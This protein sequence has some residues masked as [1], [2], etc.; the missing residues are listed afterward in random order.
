MP[1]F[2]V[3]R[4]GYTTASALSAQVVTDLLANG[5]TIVY[6]STP[7][8]NWNQGTAG[9]VFK[10]VLEAGP[11]VDPLNATAVS[12]KQPWRIMIDVQGSQKTL[13]HVGTPTTL[14]ANGIP[15]VTRELLTG[16]AEQG[17]GFQPTDIVGAIGAKLSKTQVNASGKPANADAINTPPVYFEYPVSVAGYLENENLTG[18]GKYFGPSLVPPYIVVG[19]ENPTFSGSSTPRPTNAYFLNNEN[20]KWAVNPKGSAASGGVT[21]GNSFD[22]TTKCF[23]NRTLRMTGAT[24]QA[25]PMSYRLVITPRGIWLGVWE[26]S[27]TQETATFFNWFL[28]QRPVDR[29]TGQ[30]LTTGKAPVFCV[31]SVGNQFWKFTVRERDIFRP[32]TRLQADVD[33]EDSEAVLNTEAQVS[34]SEDGKYIVTFPS[35]LNTSRYRYPHEL[36]M[37]ATTSADVVSQNTDVP[38][39]V[40]GE[41]TPRQYRALHANDPANTGMR[42]LI[43]QSGGGIS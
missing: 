3:E 40:Y 11:D 35:R 27:T 13:V 24:I 36:D 4:Y 8:V 15:P 21:L 17:A 5:F 6:K 42:I 31:N 33:L 30:V 1:G 32:S 2:V 38:L 41:A 23:I 10:V 43:L 19:D 12:E 34:L 37:I 9:E 25:Y 29:T 18:E 39:T 20:L 22:D 28:V 16:S 14:P 26:D 7:D